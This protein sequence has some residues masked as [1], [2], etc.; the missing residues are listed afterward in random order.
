MKRP[1]FKREYFEIP[2]SSVKGIPLR[3]NGNILELALLEVGYKP[4]GKRKQL[5]K[6]KDALN[7]KPNRRKRRGIIL[8]WVFGHK[9]IQGI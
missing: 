6:N 7:Q 5:K 2:N 3:M 9:N 1:K 4:K 8:H